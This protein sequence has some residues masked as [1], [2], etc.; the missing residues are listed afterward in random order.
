KTNWLGVCSSCLSDGTW[1]GVANAGSC[2][3]GYT[4]LL[5]FCSKC[6]P[7]GAFAAWDKSHCC[8]GRTNILGV[9]R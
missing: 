6:F 2:C 7:N 3:S 1:S 5:G 4:N 9:C 8:S